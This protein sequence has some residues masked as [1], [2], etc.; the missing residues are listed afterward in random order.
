MLDMQSS[1]RVE[2]FHFPAGSAQLSAR[3]YLPA[4]TPRVAVVIN[5]ATGVPRDYY[6]HFATW[7]AAERGMACLTYDYRDFGHSLRGP[8]VASTATMSDWALL[9]MPAAYAEMQRRFPDLPL[10]VIGHSVGGML[11]PLQPGIEPIA[12]MICVCSGLVH[13]SDHPWPYQA[14][15]RLFWFGHAPLLVKTLGYLPGRAIGFGTDLPPGVY[16]EWRRWCTTPGAYLSETGTRLPKPDWGRSNAQVDLFACA[17][18]DTIPPECVWR[19]ADLY[20]DNARRHLL[21]P[22]EHGVS[23]IGHLG[24]FARRNA[25]LWPRLIAP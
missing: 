10:W 8:L 22:K 15:A 20:G 21:R 24:A 19:L 17:D 3:L 4:G 16:W 23:E 18:D 7:L 9:D 14:L 6:Q 12:R 11:G 13:H 5:S 25:A 1:V 2:D